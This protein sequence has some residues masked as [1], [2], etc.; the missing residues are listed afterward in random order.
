LKNVTTM[1]H[2][3]NRGFYKPINPCETLQGSIIGLTVLKFMGIYWRKQNS[4]RTAAGRTTT[5]G[6]GRTSPLPI[7]PSQYL[8]ITTSAHVQRTAWSNYINNQRRSDIYDFDAFWYLFLLSLTGADKT[9]FYWRSWWSF[10]FT[11]RTSCFQTKLLLIERGKHYKI[12][13]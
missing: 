8:K 6:T 11:K 10:A 4:K 5:A 12:F 9:G 1:R 2:L 7:Q 3:F 13:R